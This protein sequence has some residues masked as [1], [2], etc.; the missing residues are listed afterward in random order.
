[1]A[2]CNELANHEPARTI[3]MVKMKVVIQIVN[4]I[5][6]SNILFFSKIALL[7]LTKYTLVCKE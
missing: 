2:E 3:I 1:M 7:S 4:K 6:T 5:C